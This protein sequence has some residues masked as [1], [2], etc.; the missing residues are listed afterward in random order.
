MKGPVAPKNMV[1][2]LE[3]APVRADHFRKIAGGLETIDQM[4]KSPT[5]TCT[6][7]DGMLTAMEP[8]SATPMTDPPTNAEPDVLQPGDRD[9]LGAVESVVDRTA[10]VRPVFEERGANRDDVHDRKEAGAPVVAGLGGLAI[11][12]EAS[13]ADVACEERRGRLRGEKRVDVPVQQEIL[14]RLSVPDRLN[15]HPL[16][17][18][19][20]QPLA[21]NARVERTG[22]PADGGQVDTVFVLQDSPHPEARR[23]LVF[24][25]AYGPAA[26]LRGRRDVRA[27]AGEEAVVAEGARE[28]D[29]EGGVGCG[30]A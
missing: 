16:G 9:G 23:H 1:R 27:F 29:R 14:Q 5:P 2:K 7:C 15:D 21:A 13:D 19:E 6:A 3:N 28:E 11:G 18:V 17:E 8:P 10:K 22:P 26:E 20:R 4:M 12:H 25:N 24:R 30:A